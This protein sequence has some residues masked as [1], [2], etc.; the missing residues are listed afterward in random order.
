[1]FHF[2]KILERFKDFEFQPVKPRKTDLTDAGPGVAVSNIDV[3]FRD[4]E[5]AIIQNSDYRIRCHRSKGDSGQ[6]EAERTN[7]ADGDAL[8][9]G[10]TI[11]WELKKRSADMTDEKVN[12][13]SLQEHEI[14]EEKR[15][16][17]NAWYVAKVRKERI[18]YA[19]VLSKYI[20]SVVS[21]IW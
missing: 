8:V 21:Y 15:M 10:A 12:G 4:A 7:S 19:P 1:M 18:H 9:E 16:Q 20:T 13:M 2:N 5:L 17:D 3:K 11:D 6:G 14:Y